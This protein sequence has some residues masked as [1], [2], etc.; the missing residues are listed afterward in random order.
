MWVPY[1]SFGFHLC[2]WGYGDVEELRE[3]VRRMREVGVPLES[4]FVLLGLLCDG[5]LSYF[6]VF[7]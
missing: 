2:R 6:C 4:E 1:W 5:M 7:F 3:Q